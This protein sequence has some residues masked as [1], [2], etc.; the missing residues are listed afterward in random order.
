MHVTPDDF[1]RF[2]DRITSTGSRLGA[3][4]ALP[5]FEKLVAEI[6][7]FLVITDV[8]GASEWYE[9]V[10]LARGVLSSI[11]SPG[12][13][14]PEL[15]QL[16]ALAK[17]LWKASGNAPH[18]PFPWFRQT[19]LRRVAEEDWTRTIAAAQRDDPKTTTIAAGSVVEAVALDILE[20][21]A[22]PDADHLRDSL[23]AL[24][25]PD[26]RRLSSSGK[27]TEWTPA[28]RLL[29]LGPLGLRILSE[30]THD[31]GHTLR[32]WRNLVHPQLAAYPSGGPRRGAG[33]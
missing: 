5:V 10:E 8:G 18:R 22:R 2:H 33:G 4:Y 26:R 21:L 23:N 32:D 24:P 9:R 7:P 19:G 30:R 15:E 12:R 17:K 6:Q 16:S 14:I 1:D 13:P 20:R 25:P 28:F 27:P 11:S 3:R 29:A 31:T